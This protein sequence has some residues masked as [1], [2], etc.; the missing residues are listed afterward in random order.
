MTHVVFV[1]P[2]LLETTVRFIGA[3]AALPGVRTSLIS[4]DPI[5]KLDARVRHRL[6]HHV[7]VRRGLDIDDL[8]EATRRCEAACG[9]IH[10]L[11]GTLE[12]L[13]VPLAAVRERLGLPGLGVEAALNFR[14]KARMKQVMRD[15][16]I[17]CA[18]TR[19]LG[20]VEDAL[21]FAAL[22]GFPLVLKPPAGAGAIAT[23]Q[24]RDEAALR[25]ALA[26]APP[27]AEHP[28]LCEE[29]ISGQE[30]SFDVVSV[31]GVPMWHS[32][33]HYLPSPMRVLENRWIQ[34]TVLL[35]REPTYLEPA[36]YSQVRE[37]GYAAL[38]ALG[39]QTGLSHMEWF[40][41]DGDGAPESRVLFSEIG[42]RPPGARIMNLLSTAHDTDFFRL[43]AE[44]VVNDRFHLAERGYATG[45]AYFRAKGPGRIVRVDGL[46]AAQQAFGH[47]VVESQLPEV[48]Q[49][50]ATSY[51]GDGYVIV[52]HPDTAVVRDALAGLVS[53]VQVEV[54]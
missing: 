38:A 6:S 13:Q 19:L 8:A 18:R 45:A 33:T 52:R 32:F 2:Y 29:L 22:V 9:P 27:S 11:L 40:C 7:R 14:D 15:A 43:W 36:I 10:R 23:Y 26:Q 46:G 28:I 44:L 1:A 35:P 41:R 49:L 24:V 30:Y 42:A 4:E 31:D 47:L 34:W 50:A 48:G 25:R 12:Q 17:L 16:G 51:E 39:M 21:E 3:V 5:E 53:L 37:V 54:V 20:C